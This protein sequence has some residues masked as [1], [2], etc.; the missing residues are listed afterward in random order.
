MRREEKLFLWER[1]RYNRAIRPEF[2]D[3]GDMRKDT[4]RIVRRR[5]FGVVERRQDMNSDKCSIRK[6]FYLWDAIN[7]KE[8]WGN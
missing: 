3:E 7:L 2:G 1:L 6:C 8:N 5:I 4:Y